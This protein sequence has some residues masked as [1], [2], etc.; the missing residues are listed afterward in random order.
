MKTK[1]SHSSLN[2]I[3]CEMLIFSIYT[4][5]KTYA[6]IRVVT[7]E[8]NASA[9]LSVYTNYLLRRFSRFF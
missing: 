3:S 1:R 4:M 5:S 6:S 2:E 8:N 9:F 7:F